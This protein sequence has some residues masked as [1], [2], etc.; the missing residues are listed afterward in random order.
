M[1]Q[2]RKGTMNMATTTG[3]SNEKHAQTIA[4]YVGDMAALEAH[5]EEALDRQLTQLEDE[6]AALS[7]VQAFHDMVKEHRD[8][9]RALQEETGATA[10]N[11]IKDMG[12]ALLGKAAGVIDLVRTEG[13]AKALRDDYAAF[14]LAAISY[15]M[16]Y[17]T[18]HG[19]GN[20]KVASL[21]EKYL[22]DHAE[23]IMQINQLMPEVVARELAKDGHEVREGAVMATRKIV[24]R[25][26]ETR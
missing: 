14:S 1:P 25:A 20:Q 26:C 12:A 8:T 23:A 15:S 22:Q 16:L 9:L 2:S 11:P 6:P 5:I 4:D 7:A 24:D 3:T 19:L 21:A 10:G 17:T 18:A 13:N